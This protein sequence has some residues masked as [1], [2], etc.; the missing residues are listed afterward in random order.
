VFCC[1]PKED[2]QA[3]MVLVK[4]TDHNG[5]TLAL[6]ARKVLGL[7]EWQTVVVR[8]RINR[9]PAGNIGIAADHLFIRP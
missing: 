3:A 8:G 2:L 1:T 7:K 4:F 6:D 9:D 5:K